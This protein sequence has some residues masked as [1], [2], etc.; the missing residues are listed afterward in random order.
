MSPVWKQRLFAAAAAIIAIWVGTRVADESLGLPGLLVAALMLVLVGRVQALPIGTVLLGAALVGYIVGNR[1]FAQISL[2]GGLPLLPAEAVMLVAGG[3]L[4]VQ[5]AWQHRLP[6]GRDPLGLAIVAWIA[7]CTPRMFF[8]LRAHG[9]YALRDYALVYYAAF[10]FLGRDAAERP[11]GKKFLVACLLG[12]SAALFVVYPLFQRFTD[13]FLT[14][15]TLRGVPVIYFKDDL[16][17]TFLAAG[18]VMY[19]FRYETRGGKWRLALSLALGASALLSNN[20]AAMLGLAGATALLALGGRWRFAVWQAAAGIAAALVIAA[21]AYVGSIPIERTPLYGV[22]ER[23]T[24]L[25]DPLGERTYRGEETAAKG[26]NNLFRAVWWRSVFDETVETNPWVGL[27]FGHDLAERFVREYYP[28]PSEDFSTRSPH[29]V[30]LTVF[31]RTGVAGLAP[32]LTIAALLAW[33][34]WRA[35][36]IGGDTAA[37]WAGAWVIFTSACLGVVLEGPMG[38]VVF[39]TMLGVAAA[40]TEPA[41]LTESTTDSVTKKPTALPSLPSPTA[42]ALPPAPETVSAPPS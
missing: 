33:R 36:R 38:A 3:I 31:A 26:A 11:T 20:R 12:A 22:Y 24:S 23:V 17:G 32:F 34:T 1:G 14:R 25:T 42:P 10:F 15:L 8:D 35:A 19:Y 27:G 6:F 2:A 9:A 5:C 16:A 21:V 39:W 13:F 41:E 7:V 37:L 18:A 30:L 4:L 40:Q 28:D 29:N